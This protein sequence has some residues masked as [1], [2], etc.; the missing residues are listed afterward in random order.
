MAKE[1]K[2]RPMG[3]VMAR[4]RGEKTD[5]DGRTLNDKLV[6]VGAAWRT[7]NG[8]IEFTFESTPI[9]WQRKQ[10]GFAFPQTQSFI[11]LERDDAD[12]RRGRR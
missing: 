12:D 6:R 3:D 1:E 10:P 9:A 5:A 8:H 11:L 4:V 2:N 7:E